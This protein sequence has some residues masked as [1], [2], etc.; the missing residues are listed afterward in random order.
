MASEVKTG[1]IEAFELKYDEIV[2]KL[3]KKDYFNQYVRIINIKH[4]N[5]ASK[6]SDTIPLKTKDN[7]S[8]ELKD[9]FTLEDIKNVLSNI[10]DDFELKEALN[11]FRKY[12]RLPVI[13]NKV[14][15]TFVLPENWYVVITEENRESV[16]SFIEPN[17]KSRTYLSFSYSIGA[18]YGV[19]HGEKTGCSNTTNTRAR[20]TEIT[21]EQFEEH[22]LNKQEQKVTLPF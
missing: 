11:D 13:E 16:K 1:I 2:V 4:L 3:V 22:V 12:K 20:W 7:A 19:L 17:H 8:N 5:D 6:D 14:K 10:L 15:S 18:T 21:T 9:G